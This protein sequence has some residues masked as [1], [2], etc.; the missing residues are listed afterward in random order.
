MLNNT[1]NLRRQVS[2]CCLIQNLLMQ[3]YIYI[4]FIFVHMSYL[5]LVRARGRVVKASDS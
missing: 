5:Y 1:A 2:Y 4:S 3:S